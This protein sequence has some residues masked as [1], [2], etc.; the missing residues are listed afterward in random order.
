MEYNS[1]TELYISLLPAFKVKKRLLGITEYN[2]LQNEDIWKY[3]AV[4]KWKESC[5]LTISDMVNDII[6]ADN[7]AI[8]IY[9]EKNNKENYS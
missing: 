8:D 1:L 7:K 9:R 6:H 5:N 2:N 3:L 4:N